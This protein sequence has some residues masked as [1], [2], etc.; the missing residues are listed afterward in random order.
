MKNSPDS[1]GNWLALL[2]KA[3]TKFRN[4]KVPAFYKK[5][6]FWRNLVLLILFVSLSGLGASTYWISTL[7][8][9]KLESPLAKPT[10]IYDQEGN[11]ISELSSS[12]IEPI[13]LDQVPEHAQEA[14]IAIED[15]R[16]Y[17]HQG[18]DLRAILRALIRDLK[19]QD[20]SEGGS[21]ISQQLAKNLF[22]SSDKT[23]SR[24][25]KEAGYAIKIEATLTKEE[26]LEAYINQIYF[27]EGRWGIQ[28]AARFYFGKNTEE[29]TL[30]DSALL[31]GILKGPSIY[32]PLK[33]K[34]LALERR[35]L[36][37]SLM[38]DQ[39]L[40]TKEEKT[41]AAVAPIALRT[42][43]LDNLSGKYAPYVDYVI[44]EAITRLGFTEDQLLTGGLQIYTQMDLNVQ[45]AAEAVYKNDQFFPKGKEDQPVQSSI[46]LI[47]QHTGGI[48]GLV[49]YRGESAFRQFNRASQLKR[50]PGSVIKPF[51]I[52][53]PALEKGYR[54]DSY[55][56]DGPLTID[57][58]SPK[59]WDYQTRD[60]VTME[61]AI[62]QSWNIPAV[63]LLDQ[64]GIETGK[65][66]AQRAGIPFAKSD[67][68]LSLALGGLTEGV[69]PL[70]MA[71]A[72]TA[73]ANQGVMHTAHA[74]TKITTSDG[75][76]LAEGKNKTVQVTD[77]YNAYTMTLLLQNVVEQGTAQKAALGNRPVAGKT[78]SVELPPIEE[79][80]GISTGQK[81]VWFVGY[82][83]ELTAA[84]WMGYDLTDREHYLT[85]SG[86]SGPAVVFQEVLSQALKDTPVKPFDVP[87]GYVKY[88][89]IWPENNWGEDEG[90]E[91]DDKKN[92]K[93]DKNNKK[94]NNK[95]KE[96]DEENYDDS[97]ADFFQGL[98]G[99]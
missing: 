90:D 61:D 75:Y 43:P 51:M 62:E 92:D 19:T 36:V 22:L 38:Q 4:L 85:T 47:D 50:Q 35:N 6:K 79:F 26:I 24:K 40:I 13:T 93:N 83:P 95:N 65:A 23:L 3:L 53:G 64:I 69:S 31:A 71:Q 17:E 5:P 11:K 58:Y 89:D 27:G 25:L 18:V 33:N 88:W 74:I 49:G 10:F 15:K 30:T 97:W 54:P 59:D 52:Y 56:Y 87:E 41:Q 55:L 72:Y 46:I 2:G 9:S 82:T 21:T 68:Q 91:D 7:D 39:G 44:E 34:E 70:D 80:A 32:S 84:V 77:S 78:G 8:V 48:R 37:L 29:L 99:N 98:W 96:Q 76:L 57:D 28:E 14:I 86:G 16:F 67:N 20:F 63:W 12:R 42:E 94:K 60:W 1:K 66:F 81:D 73:F 45:Q